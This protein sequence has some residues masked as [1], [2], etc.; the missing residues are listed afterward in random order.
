MSVRFRPFR[1]D[2]HA[3]ASQSNQTRFERKVKEGRQ[4]APSLYPHAKHTMPKK[5]TVGGSKRKTRSRRTK[6]ERDVERFLEDARS[7]GIDPTYD[8]LRA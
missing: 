3:A 8:E 6:Q 2:V 5:A 1:V 4:L 7:I